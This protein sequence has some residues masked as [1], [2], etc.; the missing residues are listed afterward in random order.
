MTLTSGLGG[1]TDEGRAYAIVLDGDQETPLPWV[2]VI[3]NAHFGTIVVSVAFDA[4][5]AVALAVLLRLDFRSW[6]DSGPYVVYVAAGAG[7][8]Q[9]LP[10]ILWRRSHRI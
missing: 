3:A 9:W 4:L 8:L 10:I 2:N 1:F 7:L 6:L 5:L